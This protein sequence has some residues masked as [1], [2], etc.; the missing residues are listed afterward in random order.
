ML[1]RTEESNYGRYY[2]R[3]G[4]FVK[5]ATS[6]LKEALLYAHPHVADDPGHGL[7]WRGE[8]TSTPPPVS[9]APQPAPRLVAEDLHTCRKI[10]EMRRHHCYGMEL[11][12][13]K[14]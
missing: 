5:L 8:T 13:I 14:P 3:L 11:I 9:S 6:Y 12:V 10:L 2:N 1:M 7:R 4:S